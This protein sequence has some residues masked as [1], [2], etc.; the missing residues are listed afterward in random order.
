MLYVYKQF[1]CP[2]NTTGV[3]VILSVVDANGNYRVIGTTTADSNG[4][5]S[6]AWQP[7][8]SGKYTVYATFAG[9]AA[10]YSSTGQDA[11][12]IKDAPAATAAPTALPQ[13]AAD[14]YFVP[15][16]AVILV[17]LVIGIGLILLALRKKP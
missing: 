15:A 3:D 14:T 9:S 5:Y 16:V 17:V 12:I 6:Y 4:K 7:D 1:E 10:Y 13:S 11:F 2:T 8:I